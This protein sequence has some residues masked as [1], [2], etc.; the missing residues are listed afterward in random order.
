[1]K[2]A[3]ISDTR[4]PTAEDYAGHGLGQVVITVANGLADNGHD[5]TL[6][7]GVGSMFDKGRLLTAPDE[8]EFLKH[9]LTAY[10]AV[11]DNTHGKITRVIKGLPV[12]QVSHDRE[13]S[14][15]MQAVFPTI[16]H[17]RYHG[18]NSTTSRVVYNGVKSREVA[19][20]ASGDYFAYVSTFYPAKGAN[21][22]M[23]AAWL[24]NVKLVMAGNTPPAPPPGSDYIGPL[25]GDDK[26]NFLANAKALLF[27]SAIE[28]APLTVLEAQSVGC[29][30]IVSVYGGAH[31]NMQ[32]EKTGY[33]V[34]DTEEMAARI[35]DIDKIDRAGCAEWVKENR[36]AERMITDYEDLL[37][38]VASGERW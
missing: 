19:R 29:P 26:F 1:M 14:P 16:T 24:A 34:T 21:S 11:M 30:V 5:V 18:F 13:S 36:S 12:I 15:N 23:Q 2:L 6:F 38:R 27:P 10:D 3:I 33:V 20:K 22:A 32:H 37:K 7:A 8:R 35:A 28:A 31:E 17:A 9:D 4:L 25:S